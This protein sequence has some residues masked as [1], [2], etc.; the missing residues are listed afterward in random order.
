SK[1]ITVEYVDAA[2]LV[3]S[4]PRNRD[5]KDVYYYGEVKRVTI[6]ELKR[7][8]NGKLTDE[9]LKE[10]AESSRNWY[11]YHNHNTNEHGYNS[12]TEDDLGSMMVDIIH[13]NFK[14]TNSIT[15]KKKY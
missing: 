12:Y 3:Y 5:F 4:Y 8:A 10:I 13:F 14:A 2:N 1:G 15:Y 7:L 9:Q 6:N 11:S